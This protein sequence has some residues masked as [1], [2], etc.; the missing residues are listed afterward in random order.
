MN[1]LLWIILLLINFG[2]VLLAFRFFGKT[3][4]YIWVAISAILANIQ[5]LK[6]VELFGLVATLGNII[7]GTSFLATDIL[8]EI[9][10][11]KEAQKAVWIGSFTLVITTVIMQICLLFIPDASDFAQDALVTIFKF[12]PRIVA[13]SMIAYV[14]SQS[15][16]VWAYEMW[17]KKFSSDKQIWIRNNLSTMVSQLIDSVVFCFIA[18]IGVF[19]WNVLL[20]ILVTTY[21]LKWVVAACDTPFVYI[22]KKMVDG[23]DG[24]MHTLKSESLA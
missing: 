21:L 14:V 2:A 8:S 12:F 7:Y 22:A 24:E 20:S 5:V 16:D 13:A 17:K 4:L 9:Y 18:F 11:R 6:T 23:A 19:E 1:E 15:H 3:G 10:G